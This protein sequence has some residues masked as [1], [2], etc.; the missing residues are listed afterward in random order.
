MLEA[1]LRE[2][3]AARSIVVDEQGEIIAGHGTVEAAKK[4]GITK[5]RTVETDGTE[6]V[7]VVRP[8]LSAK[9]KAELA[10]ADNRTGELAEW[11]PDVLGSL[12]GEVDLGKFF[13]DNELDLLTE[14]TNFR[15]V[16]KEDLQAPP[17][18]I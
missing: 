4:A 2:Y 8:G 3:G 5:V 7:A 1:S 11:L 10:I 9:Q 13:E 17:N 18:M 12:Q 6:I 14:T 15:T 16:T